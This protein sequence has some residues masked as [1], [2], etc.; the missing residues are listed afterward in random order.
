M[1]LKSLSKFESM[2]QEFN[3]LPKDIQKKME[4]LDG[5][6]DEQENGDDGDALKAHIE[7]LDSEV[8]EMLEELNKAEKEE[9]KPVQEESVEEPNAKSQTQDLPLPEVDLS[10]SDDSVAE[11]ANE[12][13]TK[14]ESSPYF[15]MQS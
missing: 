8:A 2:E 7:A 11:N 13:E 15:W 9:E 1:K 3:D 14:S 5:L 6:L 4:E 10:K 12:P